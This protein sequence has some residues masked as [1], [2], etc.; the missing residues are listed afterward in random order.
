MPLFT[1]EDV[2]RAAG[3]SPEEI[4]RKVAE[5]EAE[6]ARSTRL[7]N[8]IRSLVDVIVE[9]AHA[10]HDNREATESPEE[11]TEEQATQAREERAH[12]AVRELIDALGIE[13]AAGVYIS[14]NG[15]P[16]PS[17]DE[18][19]AMMGAGGG[20]SP[21]EVDH[22]ESCPGCG[23]GTEMK[24][25]CGI[26]HRRC[27][28]GHDWVGCDEHGPVLAHVPDDGSHPSCGDCA[29]A[30][31]GPLATKAA[32]I[33][34]S[35]VTKARASDITRTIEAWDGSE[36]VRAE[37]ALEKGGTSEGSKK[38]WETRRK[39]GGVGR[40]LKRVA[41][42]AKPKPKKK[43]PA[44]GPGAGL[45]L[46]PSRFTAFAEDE[47]KPEDVE[48]AVKA[49]AED[50]VELAAKTVEKAGTSEGA[51]RGWETRR[52]RAAVKEPPGE[53]PKPAASEKPTGNGARGAWERFRQA[54]K[55]AEAPPEPAPAPPP[56]AEPAP[57]PEPMPEPA[58]EPPAPEPPAPEPEEPAAPVA[59]SAYELQ[60]M[61]PEDQ[62]QT[63]TEHLAGYHED[64]Y[65]PT[66]P[67]ADHLARAKPIDGRVVA[68]QD[69][70]Q[71]AMESYNSWE[72][73][74]DMRASNAAKKMKHGIDPLNPTRLMADKI[75]NPKKAFG[76]GYAYSAYGMKDAAKLLFH[77]GA[78]LHAAKKAGKP[79]KGPGKKKVK[80]ST[81]DSSSALAGLVYPAW[82]RP[83]SRIAARYDERPTAG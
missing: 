9:D 42:M 38:G 78:L 29:S 23:C 13:D 17:H 47:V 45:E 36:W 77:R 28:K 70:L 69:E 35:S 80:K 53:G 11:Q 49:L 52:G 65:T 48:A 73:K 14:L 34:A 5:R 7:A 22:S 32:E 33:V 71:D 21:D 15:E 72:A 44:Y 56:V 81:E 50:V 41:G 46:K 58:P 27:E 57:A 74:D 67:V 10:R 66:G 24:C 3:L 55:P 25:R 62:V 75:T 82:A 37:E 20:A 1:Y 39:K 51:S 18:M 76:R 63:A 16:A 83:G 6:E 43:P 61:S 2:Y 26:G 64:V 79:V 31:P 40:W 54:K 60:M 4:K 59:V 30:E 19:A 68:T 12:A 8:G